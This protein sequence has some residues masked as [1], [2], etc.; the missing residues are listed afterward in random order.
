M[1]VPRHLL[2]HRTTL[3]K[4]QIDEL[5]DGLQITFD[6]NQT[7]DSKIAVAL[8]RF[9]SR[10]ARDL[11]GDALRFPAGDILYVDDSAGSCHSAFEK[12]DYAGEWL[13]DLS[14]FD[15]LQKG[16]RTLQSRSSAEFEGKFGLRLTRDSAETCVLL[17]EPDVSRERALMDAYLIGDI[18]LRAAV[19]ALVTNGKKPVAVL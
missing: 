12:R 10:E 8:E 4:T 13:L 2:L 1:R 9:V 6:A 17:R 15:L 7:V 5:L 11:F 14:Q 3:P 18:R 16:R 19:A